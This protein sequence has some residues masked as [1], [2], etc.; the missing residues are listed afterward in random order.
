MWLHV[1]SYTFEGKGGEEPSQWKHKLER[2]L[3]ESKK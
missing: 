3:L 2:G 1:Q